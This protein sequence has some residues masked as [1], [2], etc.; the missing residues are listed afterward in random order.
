MPSR[1]KRY[2]GA[3]HL[4]FVTFT[5]YHRQPWLAGPRRRE[6]FLK[7]L[8]QVRPRYKFVIV[9]YVVMPDHIHLLVSAPEKSDL[10]RVLQAIKQGFSRCVP[11]PWRQRRRRGQGEL[12]RRGGRSTSGQRDL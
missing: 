4:H 8:E 9:G 6:L 10:S 2:Y 1:L 5:W 7:I 11:G 3:N 12:V